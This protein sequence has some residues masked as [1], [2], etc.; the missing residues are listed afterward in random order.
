[1]KYL[2]G[3]TMRRASALIDYRIAVNGGV[4]QE[5]PKLGVP[6]ERTELRAQAIYCGP[7]RLA[8]RGHT[9]HTVGFDS[10]AVHGHYTPLSRGTLK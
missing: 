5:S 4:K 6:Y 10:R 8:G 3:I 1:M 2:G 9:S 7:R